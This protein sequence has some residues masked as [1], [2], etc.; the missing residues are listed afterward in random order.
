ML[1]CIYATFSPLLI[2]MQIPCREEKKTLYFGFYTCNH[3][4]LN[5]L[6]K[7]AKIR[8]PLHEIFHDQPCTRALTSQYFRRYRSRFVFITFV[9]SRLGGNGTRSFRRIF[10]NNCEFRRHYRLL[11]G[12]WQSGET[13]EGRRVCTLLPQRVSK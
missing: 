7:L 5:F 8:N 11:R 13:Q 10:C 4:L 6:R 3:A 9:Y 12:H 1:F 2:S